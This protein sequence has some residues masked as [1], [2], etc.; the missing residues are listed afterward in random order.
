MK[1]TLALCLALLALLWA[2]PPAIAEDVTVVRGFVIEDG[3]FRAM[4]E[5][6]RQDIS[7]VMSSI[8]LNET[9]TL[10]FRPGLTDRLLPNLAVTVAGADSFAEDVETL[11]ATVGSLIETLQVLQ[12]Q[13]PE[14]FLF[15]DE[16][17]QAYAAVGLSYLVAEPELW[18]WPE[19]AYAV[20]VPVCFYENEGGQLVDGIYLLE[21]TATSGGT[22]CYIL[23]NDPQHVADYMAHMTVS[24]DQSPFQHALAFWYVQNYLEQVLEEAGGAPEEATVGTVQVIHSS[25]VNVRPTSDAA[26]RAVAWAK[27]GA[28]YP[29]LSVAE[30]GWYRIRCTDGVTGYISPNLVRFTAGE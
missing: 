18:L 19:S 14:A 6:F 8:A 24:A 13:F 7:G 27:P 3:V 10:T 4:D 28:E 2:I 5:T 17:A 20:L 16:K 12:Q 21:V 22:L 23:Y 9:Q 30:N 26:S 15:N 1:R 11:A 29:V 25:D